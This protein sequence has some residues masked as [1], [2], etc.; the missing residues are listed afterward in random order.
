MAAKVANKVSIDIGRIGAKGTLIIEGVDIA[1]YARKVVIT[2]ETGEL[3]TVAV[4][5]VPEVEASFV[6]SLITLTETVSIR[7]EDGLIDISSLASG[8]TEYK[9]VED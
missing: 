4:E 3:T 1:K 5:L 9:R 2:A 8:S 7:N 6:S